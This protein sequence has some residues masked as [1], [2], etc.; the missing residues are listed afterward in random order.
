MARESIY[1]LMRPGFPKETSD[2]GSYRNVIEYVGPYKDIQ[3]ANCRVGIT[4]G[5]YPGYVVDASAEPVEGT[6]HAILRV[7]VERKFETADYP[8]SGTGT[9]QET[10]YEEEWICVSR[11]MLE[12]PEFAVG[13]AGTY[14]LTSEDICAIEK[15]KNEEDVT[16][17]KDFKYQASSGGTYSDLST[18]AKMFARGIQLGVETYDDFVPVIRE[19]KAYIGGKPPNAEAGQKNNPPSDADGPAGY[20]WRKSGARRIHTGGQNR[21]ELISEWTGCAKVL[22]DKDEIFWTAP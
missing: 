9:L 7:V 22:V 2:S 1:T 3:K 17:K 6:T 8:E 21:W 10:N 18:N 19:T 4:W 20:E 13:F 12:H 5:D 11:P 16:K 15:W 14:A